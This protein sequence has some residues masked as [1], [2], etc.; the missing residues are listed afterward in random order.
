MKDSIPHTLSSPEEPAH[1]S[2]PLSLLSDPLIKQE[3]HSSSGVRCPSPSSPSNLP[4]LPFPHIPSFIAG[5][6]ATHTTRKKR[7]A[8]PYTQPPPRVS[9]GR[10]Q[11]SSGMSA[12]HYG[13]WSSN[14]A[15]YEQSEFPLGGLSHVQRG[16]PEA[17][18]QPSYYFAPVSTSQA[19]RSLQVAD[20]RRSP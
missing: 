11:T 13:N 8:H 4:T 5:R 7:S 17:D 19:V 10:R 12:P 1:L 16:S 15:K 14:T 20:A 2:G 3:R 6:T 18:Q 9:S